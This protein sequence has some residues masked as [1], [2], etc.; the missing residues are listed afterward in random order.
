MLLRGQIVK[1]AQRIFTCETT[2]RQGLTYFEAKESE[3][4]SKTILSTSRQ[5]VTPVQSEASLEIN[6]AFPTGLRE[7]VLRYVQFQTHSRMDDLGA[8]W[9]RNS[10]L[11]LNG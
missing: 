10:N 2:H 1:R 11:I 4:G 9:N 7:P 3:V 5:V 6:R 8:S